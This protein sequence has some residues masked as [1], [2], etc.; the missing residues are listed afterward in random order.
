MFASRLLAVSILLFAGTAATA[1]RA[2]HHAFQQ[3]AAQLVA[4]ADQLFHEIRSHFIHAANYRDLISTA[5]HLRAD[6]IHLER[7]LGNVG[8]VRDLEGQLDELDHLAHDLSD[9]LFNASRGPRYDRFAGHC[10]P[11][12]AQRLARSIKNTIHCLDDHL[13]D[14]PAR[15]VIGVGGPAPYGPPQY[16]GVPAR[17]TQWGGSGFSIRFGR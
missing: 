10:D 16:N 17:P 12:T 11:R 8:R 9:E 3:E 6:A 2:D 15:G 5:S 13:A 1:A 7:S 14:L 4:Q